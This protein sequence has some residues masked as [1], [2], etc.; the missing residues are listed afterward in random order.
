[1]KNL[2]RPFVKLKIILFCQVDLTLVLEQIDYN[3]P[4]NTT[5]WVKRSALLEEVKLDVN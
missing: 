4:A 3:F 1:M 5:K 2:S